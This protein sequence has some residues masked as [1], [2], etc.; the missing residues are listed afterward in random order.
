MD[1]QGSSP[2]PTP[3]A[4]ARGPAF[5]A[6]L[7]AILLLSLLGSALVA[8]STDPIP[9]GLSDSVAYLVS[10]RNLS[11]GLGF[12]L[13][14]ASGEFSPIAHFPPLYPAVLSLH[15]PAG[16]DVQ[17]AA[18]YLAVASFACL[19]AVAGLLGHQATGSW[20]FGVA[21]SLLVLGSP[22]LLHLYAGVQSEQIFLP[23]ALLSVLMVSKYVGDGKTV[24]LVLGATAATLAILTRYTGIALVLGGMVGVLL[25]SRHLA[26]TRLLHAAL[27]AGA[28]LALPALWIVLVRVRDAAAWPRRVAGLGGSLWDSLEPLRGDLTLALWQTIPF[29]DQVPRQAYRVM[30]AVEGLIVI[31]LVLGMV[32]AVRRAEPASLRAKV[33]PIPRVMALLGLYVLAYLFTILLAY[34]LTKPTPDVN[35]R[36]VSPVQVPVWLLLLVPFLYLGEGGRSPRG[37]RLAP[38]LIACLVFMAGLPETLNLASRLHANGEGYMTPAWRTSET[39]RQLSEV[40][41][42]PIISNETAAL[43]LWADRP[44]Y[45]IAELNEEES[46]DLRLRYGDDLQDPVQRKFREGLATL[47]LFDSIR[48][49]LLEVYGAQ[50]ADRYESMVRD[51]LVLADLEDGTIYAYPE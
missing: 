9:S 40:A 46:Q 28:A 1:Q 7:G 4:L 2:T 37:L 6:A 43:L 8:Y 35:F 25:M 12:G 29:T 49:Q 21:I 47:V 44:A 42:G 27:F 18:R 14:T 51:L 5:S 38:L 39:I 31:L 19:I 3:R 33:E 23:L 48:G 32:A 26:R 24:A 34:A 50:G 11:R 36:M 20:T 22:R 16:I 17:V 13:M 15:G 30:V 10:A 45:D 41:P